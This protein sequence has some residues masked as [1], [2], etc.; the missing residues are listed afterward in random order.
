MT[1]FSEEHSRK[2][3]ELMSAYE[4]FRLKIF[5]W[6][7]ETDNVKKKDLLLEF[8]TW[9]NRDI[10]RRLLT[11]DLL[12]STE[13]W[14]DKAIALIYKE[15][16]QAALQEQEEIAAYAR[17]ALA[18]LKFQPQLPYIVREVFRI[19]KIEESKEQPDFDVFHNG[20]CLLYDLGNE[21]HFSKFTSQ[22]RQLIEKAYGLNEDD[23][24]DMRKMLL[25]SKNN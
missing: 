13:M 1:D 25:Q 21:Q 11:A 9:E 2:W 10:Q 3:L 6:A 17:M 5:N 24:E 14:D 8:G 4:N 16:T 20:C 7:H 23:L 12:R 22:Y 18:K 15:L 19:C